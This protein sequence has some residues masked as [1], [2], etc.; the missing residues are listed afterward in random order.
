MS[1]YNNILERVKFIAGG[2][3]EKR[4]KP[5]IA[6]LND[7]RGMTSQS[8]G[9]ELTVSAYGTV[10]ACLQMRANGLMSVDMESYRE[11][12]WEKE[13]LANSHWINRLLSNPNPYFTTSQIMKGI[14]NWY[15]VNG[16]VFLWTP[17][18]GHDVPLQMWVL[19]PTRMRVV[20][21]GDNFIKKY[22]YQSANDGAFEIPENEICH[23]ANIFPSSSKPDELIGMNIF[24]RGLVSAVLPYAQIDGEV[25]DYLQRLFANNAVPPLVVTSSENV[26]AELWQSLKEQWNEALPNYKLRALLSGGLNMSLPP[27][28]QIGISYDSVSKDVRSQIAQ[29]FGV[30]SGMLTGEFQNRA[31]AE[32]QYAVFRQQTIDPVAIYIAEELT[33]HFRRF[34]NDVLI[35]AQPYEFADIDAQIKQEEFE[36]KYGIKTINDARRER[37]Y[38]TINGGDV[39]MLANGL[40]PI[41]TVVNMPQPQIQK[42]FESKKKILVKSYPLLTSE[43]RAESWRQYDEMSQSIAEELKT[44][45]ESFVEAFSKEA[46]IAFENGN[47]LQGTMNLTEEQL[48]ELTETVNNATNQV[49]QEVLAEF[50]LGNEDLSGEFGQQLQQMSIDLNE[51]ISAS[52]EESM[53]VMKS[54]VIDTVAKNATQPKEVIADILK[55][56]FAT[57]AKSRANAI[58]QTTATSVTT[59]TQKGVFTTMG[60]KSMWNSRRDGRVRPSHRKMD[61]QV[62]NEQGWFEFPDGTMID[63]PAGRSQGG[64]KVKAENVVNCRCYLFPVIEDQVA[65]PNVNQLQPSVKPQIVKGG[66]GSQLDAVVDFESKYRGLVTHEM[67]LVTDYNGTFVREIK[68]KKT[69]VLTHDTEQIR[70]SRRNGFEIITH[71]HPDA[72]GADISFSS[73]DLVNTIDFNSVEIRAV[74]KNYNFVMQRPEKGWNEDWFEYGYKIENGQ[75]VLDADGKRQKHTDIGYRYLKKDIASKI[76]SDWKRLTTKYAKQITADNLEKVKDGT[77]TKDDL[78]V[79]VN[80]D[81][82]HKA[83]EELAKKYGWN[84][85]RIKI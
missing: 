58:A 15:D 12:N 40:V 82:V 38:D 79:L 83:N 6:Y 56:K 54:E 46:L 60:I 26:D 25:S 22:V 49:M 36:L 64:R 45:V 63:R 17:T 65:L 27:E 47:G 55:N 9:N 42:S 39:P 84:Y 67:G 24:G 52:I 57:L 53:D 43:S 23:I 31:T 7:G 85:E 35:Q 28:M 71:N 66:R 70:E 30:P 75:Y 5:P 21:G 13:E 78:Y 2:I 8:S 29:V 72:K 61:G 1:L 62:M 73:P 11:L 77:M 16:N 32:V 37:G 81:S 41:D 51:N 44:T 68:G 4:N 10:F 59:G 14:S 76:K 3:A 80:N 74:S 33:R 48:Q 18:L 50:G 69:S 20:R 34:E 19:N